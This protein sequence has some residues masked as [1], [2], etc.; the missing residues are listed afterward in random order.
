[1]DIIPEPIQF[2]WDKGNIDKN[3]KKHGVTN[4]EVEDVFTDN[5]ILV[6]EDT[7]HSTKI[8]KRYR[9]L[10][11]T[12]QEKKLFISFTIR[13]KKIRVISARPMSSKERIVYEKKGI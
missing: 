2:E 4:E 3:F 8:E 1:M 6:S 12:G 5:E 10:G 9:A 7:K 13:D 11:K